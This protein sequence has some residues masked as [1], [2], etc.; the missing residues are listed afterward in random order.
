MKRVLYLL[1]LAP[2]GLM[3]QDKGVNFEH[4][5]SWKEVQ[6]K[7]KAENK[8]IFIDCFTTWCGP[9]KYMAANV[10]PQQEVGD[11]FN[12]KFVR[13]K[14]Q[15]DNTPGDADHI[16]SWY[17]DADKIAKDYSIMAYPTFL[18]F[19]PDGKL[20][21]RVV[22]GGEAKDFIARSANALDPSKQ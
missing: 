7:A 22:G 5:L 3:A 13:V 15:M 10:F 12:A 8:Y 2:L 1:F 18:Y 16:K 14:V 19:T 17:D 9:C 11:F 4:E 21:H 6:A 20:V